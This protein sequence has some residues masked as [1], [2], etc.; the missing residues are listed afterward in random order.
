ME[1]YASAADAAACYA[2][3]SFYYASA[4]A[5]SDAART[6][7]TARTAASSAADAVYCSIYDRSDIDAYYD[8]RLLTANICREQLTQAVMEKVSKLTQE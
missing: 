2:T 4:R 7:R 8:N 6:A 1:N 3:S 5:A